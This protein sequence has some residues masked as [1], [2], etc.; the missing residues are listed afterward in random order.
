MEL[1]MK[2]II[3]NFS[4]KTNTG[5]I[6]GE[7]TTRYRFLGSE[8]KESIAPQRGMKVDFDTNTLNEAIAIY[9]DWKTVRYSSDNRTCLQLSS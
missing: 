6:S 8:W 9:K 5:V 3:L 7:D 1:Y 4:D 2:G